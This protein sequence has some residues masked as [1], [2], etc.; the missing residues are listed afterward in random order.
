MNP[1]PLETR[2][3][4]PERA[5]QVAVIDA[6]IMHA[7]DV[8]SRYSDYRRALCRHRN[9]LLPSINLPQ[10]ILEMIFEWARHPIEDCDLFFKALPEP[11]NIAKNNEREPVTPFVIAS[12]C[13]A[14]RNIVLGASQLWSNIEIAVSEKGSKKQA[15]LFSYWISKTGQRPLTVTLLLKSPKEKLDDDDSDSFDTHEDVYIL[16]TAVIDILVPHAH[17]LHAFELFVPW[18]WNRVLP[19]IASSANQLKKL[20]LR[21]VGSHDDFVDQVDLF[22]SL[23]HLTDVVLSDYLF[24]NVTL[25]LTQIESLELEFSGV[26]QCFEVLQLCPHLRTFMFDL[27]F[28]GHDDD[29]DDIPIDPTSITHKSLESIRLRVNVE[30]ELARFFKPLKLPALRFLT[31]WID[32]KGH[33]YPGRSIPSLLP[34]IAR[35]KCKLESLSLV[36]TTP[37]YDLAE[38]LHAIP[39]LRE[40]QL[41]DPQEDMKDL[42]RDPVDQRLLDLM[43]PKNFPGVGNGVG[44]LVQTR[45]RAKQRN[46]SETPGEDLVYQRGSTTCLGSNLETILFRG[47]LSIK[48]YRDLVEFLAYRWYGPSAD[49]EIQPA[50]R[51]T[52][53]STGKR[54]SQVAASTVRLRSATFINTMDGLELQDDDVAVLLKLKEAGMHVE[55]LGYDA[56]P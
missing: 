43:N 35:S 49:L 3:I 28:L 56:P 6:E 32:I 45:R 15:E 8:I 30:S 55:L 38:C 31:S 24:R 13:S 34:L 10:E 51:P 19:Q 48:K 54:A 4:T 7:D 5:D 42:K 26:H 53:R 11:G 12:V 41:Y 44:P 40:L 16:S 25:P 18:S 33:Y 17:R 52:K 14:W 29:S 47:K 9:S 21:L 39:S 1:P 36:G 50:K 23:P 22:A 46:N 20:T 2:T 27:V 37:P